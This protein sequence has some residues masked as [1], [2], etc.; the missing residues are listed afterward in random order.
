MPAE[1]HICL[2]LEYDG[3]SYHGWQYQA[4]NLSIQQVLEEA[5]LRITGETV[6]IIGAGRTDAGVH[7]LGQV[8][9]L[10]TRSA[11]AAGDFPRA[12]NAALPRDIRVLSATDVTPD[13]HPQFRAGG[14]E[15]LYLIL[16]RVNP[17]A[18][19]LHRCWHVSHPLDV[20]AMR[21]AAAVLV[22]RH[23]FS[24]FQSASCVARDPVRTLSRLDIRQRGGL[25]ELS[26][27]GNGFL[28]NM[29][30]NLVGTLVEVGRASRPPAT[31][32]EIL[33]A[34][35][36]R[37]AGPCAPAYGLYLVRVIY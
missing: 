14:K 33:A 1:R 2:V 36:R 16:N 13:F 17:S 23:D 7:A 28:K 18:L 35:D 15:Y 8:A 25:L 21:Q 3:S 4:N 29:V 9:S 34:L 12:L 19:L 10:R 6:R 37:R 5:V 20:E 22:G 32:A 24:S 30:R 31:M 11:I 26:F 27:E